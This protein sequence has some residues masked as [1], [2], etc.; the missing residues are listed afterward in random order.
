MTRSQAFALALLLAASGGGF[1]S[2]TGMGK[3]VS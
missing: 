3:A 1:A 2:F